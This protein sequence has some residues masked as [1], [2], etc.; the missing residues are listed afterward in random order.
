MFTAVAVN[1]ATI[2]YTDSSTFKAALGMFTVYDFDNFV[3]N[4][5]PDVYGFFKTLDLQIPGI[6]FDNARVNLGAWHIDLTQ[7]IKH[8]AF[9][10]YYAHVDRVLSSQRVKL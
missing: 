7:Y 6:D 9:V 10:G 4:E 8:F 2:L 3:L 1:A 5:G